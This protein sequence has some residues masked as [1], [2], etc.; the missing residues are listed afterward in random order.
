MRN[1]LWWL[2]LLLVAVPQLWLLTSPRWHSAGL[3]LLPAT[4]TGWPI[5]AILAT[6]APSPRTSTVLWL[7]AIGVAG[8]FSYLPCTV[9]VY[10]NDPA[11]P[12]SLVSTLFIELPVQMLMAVVASWAA[13][14]L[15]SRARTR[16]ESRVSL[17]E[18]P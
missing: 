4:L 3:V 8:M 15:S 16:R 17:E 13:L 5:V 12:D 11:M 2:V 7:L 14:E 9:Y 6:R 1:A 10:R 18:E